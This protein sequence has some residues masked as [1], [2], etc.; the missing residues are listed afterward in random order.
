MYLCNT[1]LFLR[2]YLRFF[3]NISFSILLGDMKGEKNNVQQAQRTHLYGGCVVTLKNKI[4][5]YG[6]FVV[7][8]NF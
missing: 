6:T 4:H 5:R 8:N 2:I 3:L 1:Y 7:E